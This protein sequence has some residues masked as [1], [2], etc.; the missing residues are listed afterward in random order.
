M[1]SLLER[2]ANRHHTLTEVLRPSFGRAG[3]GIMI[4]LAIYSLVVLGQALTFAAPDLIV[5]RSDRDMYEGELYRMDRRGLNVRR[6]TNSRGMERQAAVNRAG[7]QIAYF[8]DVGYG[9]GTKG[10]YL[11][12]ADGSGLRMIRAL[13]A[14]GSLAFS[15][16]GTQIAFVN[17]DYSL[18]ATNEIY[19][20]RA[21]GSQLRRFT[22]ASYAYYVGLSWSPD[23]STLA[24]TR[25]TP[26][27]TL[28]YVPTAGGPFTRVLSG[29]DPT[30]S[31]RGDRLIYSRSINGRKSILWSDIYGRNERLVVAGYNL[32]RPVFDTDGV[33]VILTE[34]RPKQQILRIDANLRVTNLSNN[35]FSDSDPV[36]PGS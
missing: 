31:Y 10:I 17:L 6:L 28:Y 18:G 7:T 3:A 14:C 26:A 15:P 24:F 33:S 12:N 25:Y 30:F 1:K 16:D 20:M 4:T 29:E 2:G 35:R 9:L 22:S 19:I 34:F 8:R 36:V 11:L 27:P 21:D 23:G 5:F 13:T 32:G